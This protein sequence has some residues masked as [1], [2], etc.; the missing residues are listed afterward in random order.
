MIVIKSSLKII[1]GGKMNIKE[2]EKY[3]D[4]I[5]KKKRKNREVKIKIKSRTGDEIL[6]EIKRNFEKE[7]DENPNNLAILLTII[8]YAIFYERKEIIISV[9]DGFVYLKK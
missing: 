3:I 4:E 9:R 7:I 8:Q 1:K 6:E 2:L 5:W